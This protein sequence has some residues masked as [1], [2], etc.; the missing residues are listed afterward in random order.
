VIRTAYVPHEVI[1]RCLRA[2]EG[3]AREEQI[4]E[5]GHK[6]SDLGLS[7]ADTVAEFD[8]VRARIPDEAFVEAREVRGH[9]FVIH[10]RVDGLPE[11]P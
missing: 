10:R 6:L 11:T 2:A 7:T 9:W 3:T 4:F 5:T 1:F 8:E